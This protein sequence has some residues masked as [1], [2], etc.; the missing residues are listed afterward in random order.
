MLHVK[1]DTPQYIC[2]DQKTG[3]IFSIGPSIEEGYQYIQVTEEE[4]EPIKSF[5]EKM[6]DYIV[7]YNRTEKKFVL[8]KNIYIENEAQFTELQPVDELVMYDLL[9]TV[10]KKAKR[11]YI[12]T[13][14]E[15][16]DTMKTT[17]VDLQKEIT[18]SFTKKGDPHILYDIATFNIADPK[19]AKINIK[20][21][22]SI[23]ASSDMA[24]CMYKEL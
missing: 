6:T 7:A 17:N 14:I 18:F 15:L 11:C 1:V 23:Y 12:S 8:K 10:D 24:T 21:V 4:V 20:D 16:L 5:K 2:F 9:L 22:Y 13:G 19:E 3:E